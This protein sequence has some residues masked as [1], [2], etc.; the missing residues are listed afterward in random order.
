MLKVFS[1]DFLGFLVRLECAKYLS[2]Q[3]VYRYTRA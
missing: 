1:F 2:V 3:Y